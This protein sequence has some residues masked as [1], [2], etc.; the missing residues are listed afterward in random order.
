PVDGCTPSALG[1]LLEWS[2]HREAPSGAGDKNV[3]RPKCL[4][5]LQPHRL[6]FLELRNVS[7]HL[8]GNTALTFDVL[9]HVRCRLRVASMD[10]NL[11][12]PS[13]EQP[14]DGGADTAGTAGD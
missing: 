14:G 1:N 3:D 7:D 2:R 12:S 8:D 10:R 11:R 13:R 5:D 9:V 4:F 6:D